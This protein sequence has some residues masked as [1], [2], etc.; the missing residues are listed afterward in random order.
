[1]QTS[2][3]SS[4]SSSSSSSL[5]SQ[6]KSTPPPGTTIFSI[7]NI[8]NP[9]IIIPKIEIE[10]DDDVSSSPS[11]AC[12]T[13]GYTLDS[14]QNMD[15]RSLKR[16]NTSST[17]QNRCICDKCG[18]SYAT[19]SNLSRHKQTHRA[20]DSPHAKQ[21]P[22]CDR[23]YVSMPALSMHILTHNASHECNVCGKRFS[24]LWLLQGHLRSHTGLRP[25]SCAHCGK[26]F[27]DRSN[28]RAHML[29]H[30]GDKRFECDKCGRRFALRAYLNRHLE[31]C[32]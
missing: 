14:L 5:D 32:K 7:E 22:H 19:T 24:R 13:T 29:T 12:S 16:K 21:C 26:S 25:F 15:R 10:N 2:C 1:M 4:S 18:K 20:L 17:S 30:T 27:A 9:K 28:L 6:K 31:T 23:V 11:P 8:L 3:I